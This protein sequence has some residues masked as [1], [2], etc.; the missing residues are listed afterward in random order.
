MNVA[1][2]GTHPL[3]QKDNVLKDFNKIVGMSCVVK[4]FIILNNKCRMLYIQKE[5]EKNK[6][7]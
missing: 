5:M 1:V 6:I 2:V 4:Y 7:H 3:C